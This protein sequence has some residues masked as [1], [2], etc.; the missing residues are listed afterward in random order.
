MNPCNLFNILSRDVII[1]EMSLL[2]SIKDFSEFFLY[3]LVSW[4][5]MVV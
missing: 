5:K 3:L 2:R 4:L 1:D